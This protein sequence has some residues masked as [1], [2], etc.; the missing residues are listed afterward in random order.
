MELGKLTSH[1]SEPTSHVAK[2][3]QA[4]HERQAARSYAL[5]PLSTEA[6]D[7]LETAGRRLGLSARSFQRVRKV[8]STI[9]DL[10]NA[11]EI[12]L[13]HVTEALQYRPRV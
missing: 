8:A 7:L 10:E 9:C 2:R 13:A 3:V 4:A 5:L 6:K 1:K 11:P 12:R